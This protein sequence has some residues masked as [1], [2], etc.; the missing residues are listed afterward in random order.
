[1]TDD[2][3]LQ[4]LHLE[5]KRL[6]NEYRLREAELALRREELTASKENPTKAEG[7]KKGISP[8]YA[9]L[10]AAV[11]GLIGTGLGAAIQGWS[12]IQLERQKYEANMQLESKKFESGLISKAL[13]PADENERLKFLKFYIKTGLVKDKTLAKSLEAF[14]KDPSLIPQVAVR[15]PGQVSREAPSLDEYRRLFET[16]TLNPGKQ[17]EV[18]AI[19]QKIR[20]YQ[21]RYETVGRELQI[22][23]EVIGVVHYQEGLLSFERHIH[24]GDPLTDR[25]KR[26]PRGR[27]T[28]GEPPFTWEDSARDFFRYK[29]LDQVDNW[30]IPTILFQLE[31]L[32]GWGYRKRGIN[33]PYLWSYSNH[34]SRGKYVRDGIWDPEAVSMQVGAAVLLKEIYVQTGTPAPGAG[35]LRESPR[36]APPVLPSPRR[37]TPKP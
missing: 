9:T 23:W 20:Q 17:A 13:E 30:D 12:N 22:P 3:E 24:N 14:E 15:D 25:T 27:P 5:E 18:K 32:N 29:N 16:C 34:Y 31:K 33:S 11:V 8:L 35:Q 7:D 4:K 10:L 19:V 36:P 2:V 6:E 1:M 28:A 21:S 26:W 37:S